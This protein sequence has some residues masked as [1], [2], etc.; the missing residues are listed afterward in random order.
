MDALGHIEDYFSGRLTPAEKDAFENKCVS[1]PAFAEEVALYVSMRD[2][3]RQALYAQKQQQF[4]ALHTRLS[5]Q[6]APVKS[7]VRRLLPYAAA[8]CL[9]LALGW[10]LLVREPAAR[11]LANG[12]IG[13]N[14]ATLGAT[15]SG[16]TDSL[17]RGIAAYNSKNYPEAERIFRA[18]ATRP[19]VGPEALKNLGVL[20]LVREQYA[21]ALVQFDALARQ[22]DLYANPGL[23]YKALTLMKRSAAGDRENARLLLEEVVRKNLP[24]SREAQRWIPK[25]Q[26]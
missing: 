6:P 20:Y 23:F 12:Y 15:M 14:L 25:L 13:D 11:Q 8:A 18:L 19:E 22:S 1:D 17:E 10:F 21:A 9:L 24:G 26:T 3:I 4:A 16:S 5:Q 7:M 2:G